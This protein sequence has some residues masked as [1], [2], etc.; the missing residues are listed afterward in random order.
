MI[1]AVR[2][3]LGSPLALP[4]RGVVMGDA[5]LH[6]ATVRM[7]YPDAARRTPDQWEPIAL[8]VKTIDTESGP[9]YAVSAMMTPRMELH[10]DTIYKRSSNLF[11]PGENASGPLKGSMTQLRL[12]AV[13]YLEFLVDTD[14]PQ[15]NELRVVVDR[16][17]RM[18][19][20]FKTN[21]GFGQIVRIAV[22]RSPLPSA[23]AGPD[24]CVL[25]P[26]PVDYAESQGYQGVKRL[27]A[28]A[29]PYFGAPMVSCVT[30][31]FEAVQ[32]VPNLTEETQTGS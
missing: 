19:V 16:L 28:V 20:G 13:P 4:N 2:L 11:R 8:P 12:V 31:D 22:R 5:L 23:I 30:R 3:Y 7:K 26:V 17:A 18:S 25:R 15:I 14:S 32:V 9:M 27:H 6:A 24:G 29:P 10:T 21:I 1:L